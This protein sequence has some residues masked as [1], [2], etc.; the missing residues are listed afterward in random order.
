MSTS[1][2]LDALQLP[3][4]GRQVIEA[5]AG[6]GKTWTL[7][8]LYLR[9]VLGHGR[10]GA[11]LLPP[12]ILVMTFTEAATAELRERIRHRLSTAAQCFD[13]HARGQAVPPSVTEDDYLRR[14]RESLPTTE[15]PRCAMQLHAAADWMDEAAIYTI[16]GW[17]RRMLAQH[18]LTSGH[19]FEQTHLDNR[20]QLLRQLVTFTCHVLLELISSVLRLCKICKRSSKTLARQEQLI[21]PTKLQ[22]QVG[23]QPLVR[24]C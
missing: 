12:E 11:G 23:K 3:L 10:G 5:S 20:D 17:S 15:W 7:A 16:H 22:P 6:T 18:A 13:A 8:A 14:L 24:P 21:Q 4:R 2:A 19:L 9:L 1:H